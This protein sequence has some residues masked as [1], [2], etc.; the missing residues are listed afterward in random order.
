M[1]IEMKSVWIRCCPMVVKLFSRKMPISCYEWMITH[2]K[3]RQNDCYVDIILRIC[4]AMSEYTWPTVTLFTKMFY[5]SSSN[6]LNSLHKHMHSMRLLIQPHLLHTWNGRVYDEL[7]TK[8]SVKTF[9]ATIKPL[10]NQN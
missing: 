4:Q 5:E 2:L 10:I 7:M 1:K 8:T 6:Y 3:C 9:R